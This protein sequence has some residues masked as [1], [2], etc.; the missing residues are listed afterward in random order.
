MNLTVMALRTHVYRHARL[1][2]RATGA[3]ALATCLS[4]TAHAA[5]DSTTFFVTGALVGHCRIATE[6]VDL[7]YR[8]SDFTAIGEEQPWVPFKITSAGCDEGIGATIAVA[9]TGP[10]DAVDSTLFAVTG[11]AGV[12]LQIQTADGRDVKPDGSDPAQ[13]ARGDVGETYHYRARFMQKSA[14]VTPGIGRATVV[15]NV[16][17]D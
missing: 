2:G 12:G 13:W 10:A 3:L 15:V 1:A 5:T 9:M 14:T 7:H 11:I 17:V 6:D 16:I 4:T 8:I